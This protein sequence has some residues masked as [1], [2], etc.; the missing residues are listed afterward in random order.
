MARSIDP[1][2]VRLAGHALTGILAAQ[3]RR[4]DMKAVA[5]DAVRAAHRTLI[6]LRRD[7]RR[8]AVLT[9]TRRRRK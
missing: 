2:T 3:K 1:D 5:R 6:C 4:P 9:R 7:G 8:E